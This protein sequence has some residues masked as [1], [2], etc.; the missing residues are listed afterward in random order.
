MSRRKARDIA[1]K[2]LFQV[3]LVKAEPDEAMEY[4][5][6]ESGL[7]GKDAEFSK[8]LVEGALARME[9]IDQWIS[10][11]SPEW[12]LNR[13]GTIDRNLLR[14]ATF[15]ILQGEETHPVIVI[16]EAVELAKKYGDDHS[17][18]FINAILDRIREENQ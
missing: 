5:L 17:K 11:F 8:Q 9:E 2:V 18:S 7:A 16:D 1:L 10:R 6:Q 12:P 4:L 15:E 3:D 14:L 13:M